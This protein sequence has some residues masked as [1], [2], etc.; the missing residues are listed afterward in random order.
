MD[1]P[2]VTLKNPPK[3]KGLHQKTIDMHQKTIWG[4]FCVHEAEANRWDGWHHTE[5]YVHS[6]VICAII[7]TCY[8]VTG[9]NNIT[10]NVRHLMYMRNRVGQSWRPVPGSSPSLC[11]QVLHVGDRSFAIQRSAPLFRSTRNVLNRNHHLCSL[12]LAPHMSRQF[13]WSAIHSYTE[14][15]PEPHEWLMSHN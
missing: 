2:I 8:K 10:Y 4:I 7:C 11:S 12:K 13:M 1:T 5:V 3:T 6:G 14:G 9:R 15:Q